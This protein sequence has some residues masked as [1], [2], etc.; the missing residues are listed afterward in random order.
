MFAIYSEWG[1]T[2]LLCLLFLV[3]ASPVIQS[4]VR[5]YVESE[6]ISFCKFVIQVC[7]IEYGKKNDP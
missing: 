4:G 2:Y 5:T 7:V 6:G 3:N 1:H